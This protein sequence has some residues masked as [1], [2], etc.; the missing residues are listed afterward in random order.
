MNIISVMA[1]N[2]VDKINAKSPTILLVAGVVTAVAAVAVTAKQTLKAQEIL[3]EAEERKELIA[4]TEECEE[5]T[6]EDRA[7]DY[8]IVKVQT[9]VQIAKNYIPAVGLA[10]ASVSCFCGSYGI[11]M[12]RNAAITAAYKAVDLAYKNY[13]NSIKAE[14]PD[15]DFGIVNRVQTRKIY[16]LVKEPGHKKP[17]EVEHEYVQ[18]IDRCRNYSPYARWFDPTSRYWSKDPN[19]NLE[20]LKKQES[21]ATDKLRSRG[22]LFLN[23]VFEALDLP[24]TE[25]GDVVGWVKGM[26][27]DYVDFGLY[28]GDSEAMRCFI[29]GIENVA[30]IDFNVDGVIINRI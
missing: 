5:Y 19:E 16:D 18:R 7:N 23:E 24:K 20:F 21:Y 27:D 8:K 3:E 6:E 1:K 29:N 2:A 12:R 22:H 4:D 26:G 13:R 11:L 17:T 10:V 30:L 14:N 9:A 28:N 25:A 15:K